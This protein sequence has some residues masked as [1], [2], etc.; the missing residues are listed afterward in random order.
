MHGVLG[1]LVS[2]SRH[3]VC[4]WGGEQWRWASCGPELRER[5]EQSKKLSVARF[6]FV[7]SR[8][9]PGS[10][11]LW[12]RTAVLVGC[13]LLASFSK[14]RIGMGVLGLPKLGAVGSVWLADKQTAG[15]AG[16][17]TCSKG[18]QVQMTRHHTQIDVGLSWL[19]PVPLS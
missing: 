14:P 18:L 1:P 13:R 3:C 15:C 5:A 7:A 16:G 4:V 19:I 11:G 12:W 2:H 9:V 17:L 10:G 6:L 8:R